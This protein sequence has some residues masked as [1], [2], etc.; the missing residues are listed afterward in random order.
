M[1]Y[2]AEASQKFT[3]PRVTG[4]F[5]AR[6]DAVR[7][8]TLPEAT[9]VTACPAEVTASVVM[10]VAFCAEALVHVP[11]SI[12]QSAKQSLANLPRLRESFKMR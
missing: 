12:A 5:P 11:L 7:V 2:F 3:C 9:V 6:T 8:T 4:I 1:Q 10:V